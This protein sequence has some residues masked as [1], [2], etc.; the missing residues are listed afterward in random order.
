MLT[1]ERYQEII[2][3]LAQPD[4]KIRLESNPTTL[5]PGYVSDMISR[6]L[7][8]RSE[9]NTL[10]E[11]VELAWAR[12]QIRLNDLEEEFELRLDF[13]VTHFEPAD[14]DGLDARGRAAIARKKV[15]EGYQRD[16]VAAGIGPALPLQEDIRITENA[17]IALKALLKILDHRREELS[18]LDSGVRLQNKTMDT[19]V[20]LYGKEGVLK[21]V[22]V[23]S[24]G[25]SVTGESL[26]TADGDS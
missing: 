9:V 18:K 16:Q 26:A 3:R 11:E 10:A 24:N 5:G 21:A 7:A 22:A 2:D 6:I 23:E 19:E 14:I 8:A 1:D 4:L 20:T 15:E 13:E 12:A 17:I 25:A